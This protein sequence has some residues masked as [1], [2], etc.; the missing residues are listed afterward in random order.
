MT[1]EQKE[2][3]KFLLDHHD[4]LKMLVEDEHMM[5]REI[6]EYFEEKY[7]TKIKSE[8]I[9]EYSRRNKFCNMNNSF[10]RKGKNNPVFKHPDT[11]SKISNSVKQKWD[12]GNY[13]SRIN[14]MTDLRYM[15]NPKFNMKW[16]YK[17][18]YEFYHP[19]KVCECCGKD[20]SNQKYDIH[21]VDEDHNNILLT[22]LMKLCIPCHQRMH[23]KVH[24]LPFVTVEI[25]HELQ[26]GHRLP[27]YDGKCYFP[28]GHRGLVTLRVRRR[29]DP[30]TGFAIDFNDLKKIIKTKIDD[31]LDHE[32]LNNYME[33][34]TTEYTV[35][36]LWNKLSTSLK[37]LESIT[38]AEGSKTSV[39]LTK[40]DMLQ[41]ALTGNIE[42]EWIPEKYRKQI[43]MSIDLSKDLPYIDESDDY[44]IQTRLREDEDWMW[45]YKLVMDHA[46]KELIESNLEEGRDE[47]Q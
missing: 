11:I 1:I 40:Q 7:K 18:K 3:Q 42:S 20:I 37:G 23:M 34:P 8:N 35:L 44:T 5:Y 25:S 31:V 16:L 36:W 29:I 9:G 26:Y 41:A 24:K 43:P 15:N 12:Q 17:E 6:S 2:V 47:D 27:D 13:D 30:K 38:W 10:R 14:G 39:T 45:F 46:K 33:N 19:D 4:E 32:W 22:N 28:H 21:H